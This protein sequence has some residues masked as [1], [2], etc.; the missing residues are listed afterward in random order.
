MSVVSTSMPALRPR[1]SGAVNWP[2]PSSR[3]TPPPYSSTGRSSGNV[4]LKNTAVL[5]EPLTRAASMSSPLMLRRPELTNR[6]TK[7]VSPRPVR[8]TIHGS[9]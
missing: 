7:A 1:S 6:Y 8:I 5:D 4:T 9:V 3:A 2:R